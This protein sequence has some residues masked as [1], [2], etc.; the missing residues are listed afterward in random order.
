MVPIEQ[1]K[2]LS[3][4]TDKTLV[5]KTTGVEWC[6]G[7]T[8]R[9]QLEQ[10]PWGHLHKL[11][12]WIR[13]WLQEFQ[14]STRLCSVTPAQT[15]Y[16]KLISPHLRRSCVRLQLIVQYTTERAGLYSEVFEW[17]KEPIRHTNAVLQSLLSPMIK[18]FD[19]VILGGRIIPTVIST[20]LVCINIGFQWI[21]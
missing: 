11:E 20:I 5:F 17:M 12:F 10:Y 2:M 16:S 4:M 3:I 21:P 14:D 13:H 8:M 6:F 18:P 19:V 15:D 9:Y 1:L 7:V